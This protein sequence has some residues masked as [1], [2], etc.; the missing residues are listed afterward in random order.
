MTKIKILILTLTISTLLGCAASPRPISWTNTTYKNPEIH[1]QALNLA[2]NT[3]LTLADALNPRI[4][5]NYMPVPSS[6][7]FSRG[8]ATGAN[9]AASGL[10]AGHAGAI[11]KDFEKC[12][13]SQGWSPVFPSE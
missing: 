2:V 11:R 10:A 13:I 7:G 5:Q 8:F 1:N 9:A 3:C 12:M 4:T 6:G